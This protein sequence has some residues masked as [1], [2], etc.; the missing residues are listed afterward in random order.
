MA[1]KS[2]G[3]HPLLYPESI[4]LVGTYDSDGKPN[5]ATVAW[6]GICNSEPVFV[7]IALRNSRLTHAAILARKAFTISIPTE[8]M[9]IATDYAGM[10]SG[11]KADKFSTAGLTP[12]AAEYVD[13]P[14]V[15]ECPVVLECSLQHSLELPSHTL[16]IGEVRDVKADENCLAESGRHPDIEK[17]KPL[18]YDAGANAYYAMG[19]QLGKAFSV[20]KPLLER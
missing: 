16:F 9:L 13:A 7:S 2:L 3:A 11:R 5:V 4:M 19:R 14:Y 12:M 10:V 20:G 15:A 8:T 1:K 18:A 6:G 17:L